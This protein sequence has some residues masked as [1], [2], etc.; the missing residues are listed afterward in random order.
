MGLKPFTN[1]TAPSSTSRSCA[2]TQSSRWSKNS[3][4]SHCTASSH[5]ESCVAARPQAWQL[6]FSSA[7]K[8][9]LRR[10]RT[11]PWIP[12]TGTPDLNLLIPK[13]RKGDNGNFEMSMILIKGGRDS[14]REALLLEKN[15]YICCGRSEQPLLLQSIVHSVVHTIGFILSILY[16]S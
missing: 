4:L 16:Q 11:A 3:R 6:G 14:A 7:G 8:R 1:W 9:F 10:D 15:I 2:S 5:A 12:E 13:T